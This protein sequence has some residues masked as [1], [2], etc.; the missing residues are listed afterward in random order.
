MTNP[1]RP[2]V[3]ALKAALLEDLRA[4]S[5]KVDVALVAEAFDF[6]H[7]AHGEQVRKSGVPYIS[8]PVAAV[9]ILVDLLDVHLDTPIAVA[10]L[11]HDVVEDTSVSL[12]DLEKRFGPEV[13]SLVDGVTKISGFHFDSAR[14]EQA[15]NFRKMLLSMSRDL[16][17]IFIKLADRLHNMRTLEYLG[18]EKAQRIARETRDIYAPLAHRLG[19]ARIK[20]ELEDLA[21]KTLDPP[22]YRDLAE[23]VAARREHRESVLKRLEEPLVARLAEAGIEADVSSRPKHFA[24]IHEKMKSAS[25]AF[26]QIFDLLGLRIVTVDKSDCYRVLGVVHDLWIP[27]QDRFKDYIATPKS[28]LYQS[29]HTT[30]IVPGGDMVEIQIRTREMHRTAESGVAAHYVYKGGELDPHLDARLGGFVSQT[31]DWQ[32]TASDEDYM[33]FLQTALYQDEVFVY[34]PR[35]E[36]KRL[37]KGATPLDFAFLIHTEVGF[38]CVGARVNGVLVPLRHELVNGDTVEVMTS[39]SARPHTDWL[40][41]VKTPSARSKIRHWLRDQFRSDAVT[42]GKEMLEREL[43]KLRAAD[44]VGEDELMDAAQAVGLS[45]VESLYAHLGQGTR[46]LTTIV[47]RL[48]PEAGKEGPLDRLRNASAEMLRNLTRGKGHGVR[49]HGLDN[50]LLHFARCCQPVPGDRVVGIVTQGRGVSV[51]QADCANTFDDRVPA[52]RRVEVTWDTRPD[53]V[54]PVRLVVYGSDRQG[55][56]ADI[57]K[58]IAAL[59]VNIRSAGMASEDKTAR[60]VFLVEVPNLRKL[61]ETL[62]AIQRVK[63]VARVERQQAPRLSTPRDGRGARPGRGR[64]R[65]GGSA[66]GPTERA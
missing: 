47:R 31:A 46:S 37:P 39:P 42:M 28:N 21:L 26:D 65:D 58:T 25:R 8:H 34:T 45:D 15:E 19:I 43:K 57:T 52:E 16:R 48:V 6:S 36:L 24:S 56:L 32:T 29:L 33:E 51:H 1:T 17:V 20:R 12:P 50:V 59:K 41:I 44:R 66:N 53:E 3:G 55:M 60:G 4:H 7:A 62:Q 54:F 40:K 18:Q 10:A 38:H 63:G 23:R 35:R 5:P 22:A 2:D 9:H 13:G 27:V 11:L 61:T 30:V 14:R 49:L 64:D